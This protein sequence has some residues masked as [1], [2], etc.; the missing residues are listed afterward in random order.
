MPARRSRLS[1]GRYLG[2]TVLHAH[3]PAAGCWAPCILLVLRGGD[4]SK[5]IWPLNVPDVLYAMLFFFYGYGLYARRHLIDRL[6]GADM[7]AVQWSIAIVVFFVHV[8]LIGVIDDMSKKGRR[9]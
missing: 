6:R 2:N 4:E 1:L 7:M 9:R 8:V 5:P 3:T